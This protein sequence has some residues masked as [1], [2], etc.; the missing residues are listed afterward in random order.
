[1]SWMPD[2]LQVTLDERRRVCSNDQAD[3]VWSVPTEASHSTEPNIKEPRGNDGDDLRGRTGRQQLH[4]RSANMAGQVTSKLGTVGE[5]ETLRCH[6]GIV[7]RAVRDDA[8]WTWCDGEQG[9]SE[10]PLMLRNFFL[11]LPSSHFS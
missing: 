8:F 6:A 11:F 5:G 9:S 1:M 3:R 10:N 4:L 2:E 7:A